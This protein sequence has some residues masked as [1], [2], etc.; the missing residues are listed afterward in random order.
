MTTLSVVKSGGNNGQFEFHF[1]ILWSHNSLSPSWARLFW[2]V[3]TVHV[4]STASHCECMQ[5]LLLHIV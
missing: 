2:L 4:P 3:V 5:L 1:V